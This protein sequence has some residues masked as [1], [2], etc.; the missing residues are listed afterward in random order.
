MIIGVDAGC[1]G[2]AD[3]RLKVGVYQLGFNLLKNLSKLDKKNNY[4]LYSF[5]PIEKK[6]LDQFGTNFTNL[7]LQPQ[8]GWLNLR[9]SW[10]FLVRKP[11]LFLG[12]GQALPLFHPVKSI[13][14]VYDLAFEHYPNCYKDT[15]LRLSRQTKYAVKQSDRIIAISNSTK[16]DLVKFYNIDEEKIEVIY[17]GIS[18]FS[19]PGVLR[20]DSPGVS[21]GRAPYFLPGVSLRRSSYF[22]FVG[23]LKPIKNIPRIIEAFALFLKQAKKRYKLVLTGSDYWLDNEM[24]KMINRVKIKDSIINLGYVSRGD[25]SALYSGAKAL[26]VPSLYEGFGLPILEAMACKIPVITG[27]T[28]SMPEVAGRAAL[29]VD[30]FNIGE[31][32]Q[33]LYKI[34][35]D[36]DLVAKLRKRGSERVKKFS[37]EKAAKKTLKIINHI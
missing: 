1:L 12:L 3:E 36:E 37:W 9:L 11:D 22:L 2:V 23:S 30:P 32:S 17:P 5:I 13:V 21:L 7:V 35:Q 14:F 18:D 25:L 8:K 29:L 20:S 4:S 6:I 16:D 31:I 26:V 10:E 33:A 24:K 15:Y 28:G 27:N 19:T 34:D